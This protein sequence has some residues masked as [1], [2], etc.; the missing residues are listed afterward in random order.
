M[1]T[2]WFDE[3]RRRYRDFGFRSA[4]GGVIDIR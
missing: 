2:R 3:N 4:L 1:L